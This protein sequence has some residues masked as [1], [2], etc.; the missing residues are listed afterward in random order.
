MPNDLQHYQ[1]MREYLWLW[2]E[3]DYPHKA[4]IDKS[5]LEFDDGKAEVWRV[6]GRKSVFCPEVAGEPLSCMRS[7][8]AEH[9]LREKWWKIQKDDVVIDVGANYGSYTLPAL[10]AGAFVLAVEPRPT[11]LLNNVI[12][13]D[14]VTGTVIFSCLAGSKFGIVEKLGQ[15]LICMPLDLIVDKAK[16][17]K[18][19]WI[20]IDVEGEE[21][22]VL[23]GAKNTLQKYHPK[24]IVEQH[25]K[26][27]P[28]IDDQV[29]SVLLPL[30]YK[31]DNF[32]DKDDNLS[33]YS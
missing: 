28:G 33:F 22:E 11:D 31:E 5:E 30:G 24:L 14:Y 26:F 8:F 19:D 18:V 29:R 27:V 1:K 23:K 4:V 10:E 16:V 7:F 25:T 32:L 13:N 6:R 2:S 21:V 15:K 9:L 3:L 17:S 20:K 12:L